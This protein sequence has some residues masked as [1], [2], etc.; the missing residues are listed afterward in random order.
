MK[1]F[2]EWLIMRESWED[3][4]YAPVREALNR[5]L[6]LQKAVLFPVI[7]HQQVV[8]DPASAQKMQELMQ[9]SVTIWHEGEQIEEVVSQFVKQ[10]GLDKLPIRSWEPEAHGKKINSQ[11][12]LLN[13]IFGGDIK[14]MLYMMY[15]HPKVAEPMTQ[16]GHQI[17]TNHNKGTSK[18]QWNT[19]SSYRPTILEVLMKSAYGDEQGWAGKS[20]QVTPENI[21]K[22]LSEMPELAQM[23]H[24]EATPQNMTKF[25]SMG[26]N[27]AYDISYLKGRSN[28]NPLAHIE[29]DA[30]LQRDMHL[31]ELMQKQGGIFF[32]GADH[33]GSVRK[34]L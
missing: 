14:Y 29:S 6:T 18:V 16:A 8:T 17:K 30:Q 22:L 13:D 7:H 5:P 3:K 25:L 33:V 27:L 28:T 32:A 12:A 9:R 23:L 20:A 2:C 24:M 21:R 26:Q 1:K 11:A 4:A 15:S 19:H 31:V 10:N 34:L